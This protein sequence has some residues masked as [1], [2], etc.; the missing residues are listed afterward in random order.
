MNNAEACLTGSERW[1]ATGLAGPETFGIGGRAGPQ[2]AFGCEVE[3]PEA[4]HS[5][6]KALSRR[7]R[8]G[9]QREQETG[10]Q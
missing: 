3:F 8:W 10:S 7:T 9:S 4:S 5:G 2:K 6:K 1:E